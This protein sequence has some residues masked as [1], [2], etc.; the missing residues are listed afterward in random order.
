MYDVAI[1][2]AGPAGYV[3][4]IRAG[5]L[6]LKTVIIEKK[7]M[8]GMCLNWGC[9]P[10]KAVFES[11][12]LLSKVRRAEDFGL[13]GIQELEFN[14]EHVKKRV[15]RI[16]RKLT[17][18]VEFLLKKNKVEIIKET[19]SIIG[20]TK[21]MAGKQL[22]EAKHIIIAT[23]SYPE[24]LP[25]TAGPLVELENFWG[26]PKLPDKPLIFGRG[27][28]ALEF[29]QFF[30]AL[31]KE[32]ALV[33][34]GGKNDFLPGLDGYLVDYALQHL[35]KE[36]IK[37]IFAENAIKFEP[38]KI[39]VDNTEIEYDNILNASW[40]KAILPESGLDF[41]TDNG[42]LRVNDALQTN[43]PNIYAVGDVNGLNYLAHAA[44]AQGLNAVNHIKGIRDLYDN[45]AV[46]LNIYSL[47]EM[48]QL[49]LT[50]A[51]LRATGA[52]Y[53][54]TEFPLS[55]N[56]K[57][58]CEGQTEGSMRLLWEKRYGQ[59]M[60]VQIIADSATDLIAEAATLMRVE[61]T[62]YDL[63]KT[64]HAHPTVSEVFMEL[65]LDASGT[66]VHK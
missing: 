53:Q 38:Q 20:P 2:G 66:P 7:Y 41:V 27:P 48:A 65:G 56:G 23:G 61:G 42:Y 35:K 57:A 4:A 11:A 47:P 26:L 36:G 17:K 31:G 12:K 24:A 30:H 51:E 46:P 28:N 29:T 33:V 21:I 18:G 25:A 64:I 62:V 49:G 58:L 22:I 34:R 8:G 16:T 52:D 45:L 55:A 15:E 40:R 43:F 54:I 50:E 44:S 63:A 1:I 14:W 19:A 6:G 3:A 37:I 9:I 10:T 13:T 5:Q 59:V 60:G 32:V 39:I